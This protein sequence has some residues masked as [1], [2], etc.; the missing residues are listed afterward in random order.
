MPV[1]LSRAHA[2]GPQLGGGRQFLFP[3]AFLPLLVGVI[4]GLSATS[5]VA[6]WAE[7]DPDVGESVSSGNSD[8]QRTAIWGDV[9]CDN[10]VDAHDALDILAKWV[11]R[12][13]A[14][15]ECGP[16]IFGPIVGEPII[17]DGVG[18]KWG[19][20]N[21]DGTV[22]ASDALVIL[23]FTAGLPDSFEGCP[24]LGTQVTFPSAY[25]QRWGDTFCDGVVSAVDATQILKRIANPDRLD[26]CGPN[27]FGP[28]V[29]QTKVVNGEQRIWGDVN[30]SGAVDA[31]D[32]LEILR[33]VAG[34]PQQEGCLAIGDEVVID[35]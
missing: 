34:L 27:F 28:E 18:E 23:R 10:Q 21:C 22:G 29:M 9:H 1:R 7:G 20:V 16:N 11:V 2:A 32:S 31:V 17:L 35:Y 8:T 19:D 3:A 33:F 26:G 25:L 14:I 13:V 5:G 24:E 30:C 6:G 12:F 4:L 15:P